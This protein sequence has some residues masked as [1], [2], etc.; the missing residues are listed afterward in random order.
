LTIGA[1][2]SCA[3]V[4]ALAQAVPLHC[5]PPTP[6]TVPT[7]F[8]PEI[9]QPVR[10]RKSVFE[11]N[12]QEISR[13]KAAYAALRRLHEEHPE[14]ARG[15]YYQGLVHCW[16]CSGALNA[17]VGPEI[18]NGWYFL[19]W[20]RAYLH[21]H[22]RILAALI[23]DPTFSL[24]YWDWDTPGRNR[25]PPPYMDPADQTNPLF[26]PFRAI[27]ASTRIP[28]NLTGPDVIKNVLGQATFGLFA[29]VGQGASGQRGA[30]ERAPHGGVHLWVANPATLL[31]PQVNMGVLGT[32][33]FD[34]VFFSHHANIDRLWTV[35]LN[36][37]ADPPHA[38]PSEEA[39][40][41]QD[42]VFYDQRRQWT[43]ILV[44]QVVDSEATLRYRYQPPSAH[45]PPWPRHPRLLR[46]R[47]R[48]AR[49]PGVDDGARDRDLARR[50]R[51]DTRSAYAPR[52][53]AAGGAGQAEDIGGNT[54][55]SRHF[56]HRRHPGALG[57][58][59]AGERVPEPS[60]RHRGDARER[61]RVRRGDRGGSEHRH[62]RSR[63]S[64][65]AQQRRV[66]H[67]GED[68]KRAAAGRRRADGHAGAVPRRR[69]PP[70]R[71]LAA[72]SP[73]LHRGGVTGSR[74]IPPTEKPPR[75]CRGGF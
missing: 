34:P 27:D 60:G 71:D 73:H 37:T 50:H 31:P 13:L 8:V 3:S 36:T 26:D 53:G 68:R 57:S 45:N 11:L 4:A 42:F 2:T 65:N 69:R 41:L 51:A 6:V 38:N 1:V 19:P 72:L 14:D 33:A 12:A 62:E 61:S 21:L 32:A 58:G 5:A 22:E 18:H 35:W 15:W 44:D 10:V 54:P 67:H 43:Q 66:R 23:N 39:W 25:F 63:P 16:Y 56:A 40:L 70:G 55:A 59:R 20:H 48:R 49:P 75:G 9:S 29:G 74:A 64:D 47:P 28:D 30:I 24:P 52:R 17:I 7:P 46:R